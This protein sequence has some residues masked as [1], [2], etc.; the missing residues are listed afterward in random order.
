MKKRNK[1]NSS[2]FSA[3]MLF[4]LCLVAGGL[5]IN[6]G[7]S[8]LA[9]DTTAVE[10]S[11]KAESP[12]GFI[13]GVA[14]PASCESGVWN[15]NS[16]YHLDGVTTDPGCATAANRA[17]VMTH[18]LGTPS[19]P[20]GQ[21]VGS[22]E[23]LGTDPDGDNIYYE[24]NWG[25]AVLGSTSVVRTNTPATLGHVY[26]R[27]GTYT[28]KS[29]AIE[30]PSLVASIWSKILFTKAFAVPTGLQSDWVTLTVTVVNNNPPETPV[31]SGDAW[32][33]VGQS[34]SNSI[35]ARDPDGDNVY[36][37]LDWD[38][39]GSF[40]TNGTTNPATASE[41]S[42]PIGH[43][44][45]TVGTYTIKGRAV[46]ANDTSKVSGL[47][48]Y[49]IRV[50]NGTCTAPPNACGVTNGTIVG[51]QCTSPGLPPGYGNQC[52][53]SNVCGQGGLS[54][55]IN[56]SGA[57]SVTVAPSSA[58][59][60]CTSGANACG[61]TNS[62]FY[63]AAGTVCTAVTPPDSACA[64]PPVPG[65][66]VVINDFRAS[67]RLLAVGKTSKLYWDITGNISSCNISYTTN[68]SASTVPVLAR[69]SGNIGQQDT[70]PIT[71]K[72]YYKLKCGAVEKEAIVSPYSLTE[73]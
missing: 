66:A 60:P 72:R 33:I 35:V 71:E 51:G 10:L 52:G 31:I 8:S 15:A 20:V 14:L 27:V 18:L 68:A 1:K 36:Y 34:T 44:Y 61:M 56:C 49:T 55:T 70:T 22:W 32:A 5:Y 46:Q 48:T 9:L 6:Q 58:T 50:T 37:E 26:T 67:P 25:D 23:A 45:N 19:V 30:T 64:V 11:Y 43:T 73:I 4:A 69:L 47:G 40:N 57:C 12:L 17:P 28:I 13:G 3:I 54:G 38:Y 42:V 62:V 41:A 53:P 24:V 29:R 16:N 2:A 65:P 39:N 7:K 59:C 21:N 63:N